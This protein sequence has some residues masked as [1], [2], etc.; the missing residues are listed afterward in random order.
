MSKVLVVYFSQT[1]NTEAMAKAVA[2]GVEG[3]GKEVELIEAENASA[4]DLEAAKVF[5]LGSPATGTEEIDDSYMAPL[6]DEI[7]GSLSGKKVLLFGS[8]DW[9]DGEFMRTWEER[10]TS[11]GAKLV[12][13]EGI[14]A[15]LS[16]DDAAV[17]ALKKAGEELAAL[18]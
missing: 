18:I 9:G 5:A 15:N 10:V 6:M 13:G 11:A 12:T 14:T 1:G 7:E 8:Y 16:P 4:A 3:A 2:K 17:E